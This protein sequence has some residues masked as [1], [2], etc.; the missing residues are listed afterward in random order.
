[1]ITD[2]LHINC[3]ILEKSFFPVF[4]RKLH[5]RVFYILMSSALLS[6]CELLSVYNSSQYAQQHLCLF[7]FQRRKLN[8]G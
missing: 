4:L 6:S 1:M 7:L 2:A 8:V 3:F 5:I